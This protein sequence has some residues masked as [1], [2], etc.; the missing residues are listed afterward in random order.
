MLFY[1]IIKLS[2]ENTLRLTTLYMDPGRNSIDPLNDHHNLLVHLSS[3]HPKMSLP[4]RNNFLSDDPP[5]LLKILC[6]TFAPPVLAHNP[7]NL[8]RAFDQQRPTSGTTSQTSDMFHRL[9]LQ[10]GCNFEP[11]SLQPLQVKLDMTQ[12]F[13]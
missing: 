10:A 8:R 7:V 9:N 12:L 11:N 4:A 13:G 6:G 5:I 1:Y 2:K 3:S